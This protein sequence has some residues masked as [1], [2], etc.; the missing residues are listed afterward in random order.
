MRASFRAKLL[1]IVSVSAAGPLITLA[2]SAVFEL[3]LPQLVWLGIACFGVA[4]GFALWS[5]A[6]LLEDLSR[7]EERRERTDWVRAGQAR[8]VHELQG[9]LDPDELGNRAAAFLSA[10]L[11]AAGAALYRVDPGGNLHALGSDAAR[12]FAPG[13]GLVGQAALQTELRV[14][15]DVPAEYLRIR[16]GRGA[17]TSGVLV[18]LP[19]SHAGQVTGVVEL[20][21]WQACTSQHAEFLIAVRETLQIAIEVADTRTMLRD[22]LLETQRQ[23]QRLVLQEDDLRAI[24]AELQAQQSELRHANGELHR[25]S[26]YKSQFLANMSHE[27][28]TPLNSMLL[29]SKLLSEN[30]AGN[31]NAKQVEY[32]K[33]I[34]GAGRD[35]LALINQVLDLAKIESGKQDLQLAEVPLRDLASS[36]QRLAE[37]LARDK[38]LTF[39]IELDPSA[40]ESIRTDRQKLEQILN[41]LLGNAIKFTQH[42]G[43]SL[44]IGPPQPGM[45]L[46]RSELAAQAP[47]A[48]SVSDTGIGIA[49]EHRA[50]VFEPFEQVD[51]SPNRRYGGT[52]LG[53]AIARELAQLLG[54]ELTLHDAVGRGSVFVCV[55]PERG[56]AVDEPEHPKT[57]SAMRPRALPTDALLQEHAAEAAATVQLTGRKLLLVDDDMR[58]V[59]AVSALLRAKGAEVWVA[60]TGRAALAELHNHPDVQL[61]LMDMMMPDMDGYETMRQI[62]S[63]PRFQRLPIVALTAKAM[64]G[65]R[66]KCLQA[67]AD[68][69]LTKPID[70]ER[71]VAL[72]H[73]RAR[74]AA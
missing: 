6:R 30:E 64:P 1:G 13:E 47:V 70:P 27:L 9:D 42:G 22:L 8:L 43:V 21:F 46:A 37:P 33:T 71:L 74:E 44:R 34:H 52:G 41:N 35:L 60:D 58:T 66:E 68:D 12:S 45:R 36:A 38:N 20:V 53:L 31:L 61:V 49:A 50:S 4:L 59:Y 65:D 40:P 28:R 11:G 69:Y 14:I 72:V 16:S 32:C 24:N 18:L 7:L 19:L 29:L 10:Y 26:A 48:I 73:E 23:A 5:S 51:G 25:V 2:V 55:L 67:G 56:P 62:R 15:H 3:S 57:V 39:T 54:G 17:A 63:E